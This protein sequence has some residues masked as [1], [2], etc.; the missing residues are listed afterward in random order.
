MMCNTNQKGEL[1]VLSCCQATTFRKAWAV[2]IPYACTCI[3]IHNIRKNYKNRC[4]VLVF[5]LGPSVCRVNKKRNLPALDL[6]LVITLA[7]LKISFR[8]SR[9][10]WQKME[11]V[12]QQFL[13]Y[14]TY[15]K[16]NRGQTVYGM[17]IICSYD[18]LRVSS[19]HIEASVLSIRVIV[20]YGLWSLIVD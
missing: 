17:V 1:S 5:N 14:Y 7:L 20:V 13:V 11:S 2:G 9:V 16:V 8:S 6:F 12:L 18:W 10:V 3:F 4:T 19:G 15:R